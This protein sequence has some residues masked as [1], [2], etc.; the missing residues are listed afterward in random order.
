MPRKVR[1]SR[2]TRRPIRRTRKRSKRLY[3]PP[4]LMRSKQLVTADRFMTMLRYVNTD[5]QVLPSTITSVTNKDYFLNGL[6]DVDPGFATAAIPGFVEIGNLYNAY[7]A[8]WVDIKVTVANPYPTPIYFGIV[9]LNSDGIIPA[10]W[11]SYQEQE[12][13][14]YNR[15]VL[16]GPNSGGNDVKTL[17]MRVNFSQLLGDRN[18]YQSNLNYRGVTP[19]G[20][21]PGSNPIMK[22]PLEIYCL[23]YISSAPLPVTIPFHCKF[24]YCVEFFERINV[25]S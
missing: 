19:A 2:T 21:N 17:R 20:I 22:F 24:T 15:Q 18:L 1:R 4:S 6:Y 5:T 10:S 12:G 9:A 11:S 7:R 23:N 3:K 16:M 8:I 13:N 14:K 25:A